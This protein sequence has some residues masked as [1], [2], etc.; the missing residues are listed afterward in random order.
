MKRFIAILLVALMTVALFASCKKEDNDKVAEYSRLAA[1]H[2]QTLAQYALSWILKDPRVTSV[3]IGA[4]RPEQILE[5]VT[6]GRFVCHI[7]PTENRKI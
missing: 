1:E 3:I 2:G 4:S 5:N 7:L 6:R